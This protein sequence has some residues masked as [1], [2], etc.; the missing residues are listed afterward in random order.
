MFGDVAG[1]TAW[2]SAREPSQVF[3][4][5]ETIYGA[6]DKVAKKNGVFKVETI[7][8]CYL[9]VTGLPE[10]QADHAVRSKW[11]KHT[12][13]L[14]L[15]CDSPGSVAMFNLQWQDLLRFVWRE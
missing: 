4:L 7:G 12:V 13:Q 14:L 6:F 15:P 9:A 8:D 1:F 5:L 3:M 10:P 2:A 11:T